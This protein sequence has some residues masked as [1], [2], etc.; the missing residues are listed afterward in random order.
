MGGAVKRGARGGGTPLQINRPPTCGVSRN[1]GS[2]RLLKILPVGIVLPAA[3]QF[4][5]KALST[6]D[7]NILKALLT[8]LARHCATNYR[9]GRTP[10]RGP[11]RV[12]LLSAE[13]MTPQ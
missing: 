10:K 7:G 5:T 1:H 11:A 13:G 3:H 4:V 6:G 9:A 2:A 8:M 12:V